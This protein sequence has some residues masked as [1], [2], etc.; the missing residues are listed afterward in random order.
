MAIQVSHFGRVSYEEAWNAQ[1]DL[2]EKRIHDEIPDTLIVVEHPHVITLGRKTPGVNALMESGETEWQGLPLFF[3]ERGGDATY[4]GPG[5]IVMYPIFRLSEKLG[6]RGFL[7]LL[8]EAI[9][10]AL[11][12]FG[13]AGFWK[14]GATGV[15]VLD[16][17]ERERKIASLGIAARRFVSYHG[18]ALNVETDLTQFAKIQPCGFQPSVMTSVRQLL[19]ADS[20]TLAAVTSALAQEVCTRFGASLGECAEARPST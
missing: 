1:R 11:A 14:E 13:I 6:P 5:Q 9:I 17:E 2:L 15:W 18:L 3:V 8:E 16:G 7:R 19:G 10:A 12:G 20:P 4:H